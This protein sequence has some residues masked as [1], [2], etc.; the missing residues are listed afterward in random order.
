MWKPPER[1]GRTARR[2]SLG[3]IPH[4]GKYHSGRCTM[5]CFLGLFLNG[6]ALA[7]SLDEAVR[8]GM[9]IH[10][11]VSAAEA[12]LERA[13][14]DV[15]IARDGYW[16]TLQVSA[17]PENSLTGDLGYDITAAQM[18]YDWGRVRSRV[19]NASAI[20]R[21]HL[22]E[23]RSTKHEAALDIIETYLDV[24]EAKRR[25][26]AAWRYIEYVEALG[27]LTSERGLAGY[28]DRGEVERAVL[29]LARARE[30]LSIE[31]SNLRDASVQFRELV[32]L[33]PDNLYTPSPM[34]LT[35]DLKQPQR[36]DNAI[37]EAPLLR[38]SQEAVVAARAEVGESR[39]ALRPQLNLE[40]SLLRREIGRQM[41]DDAVIAL[42]LRMDAIQGLSN[43]RRTRAAHQRVEAAEWNRRSMQRD[44][45]RQLTTLLE[46]DEMIDWRLQAL[47][48]QLSSTEDV[49]E[50]YTEQFDV[51][52]RDL[53]DLLLIQR[54]RFEAERQIINLESERRRIQYRTAAQ[55]GLLSDMLGTGH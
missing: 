17:G 46:Q 37:G 40:G 5:V 43:V 28:T 33:P 51:G 44:L 52:L 18:L 16:P 54:D 11:L 48:A 31:E 36:L 39:A 45:R 10:P 8:H 12:E 34:A 50:A 21:Q 41:E 38:Q 20:E 14:I 13:A 4:G 32:A 53:T 29:E 49:V 7:L 55:L 1:G 24:I 19:D 3:G 6:P 25:I 22:E 35:D 23:L 47:H 9:R 30:Q 15:D 42:R 26:E 27:E 2:M